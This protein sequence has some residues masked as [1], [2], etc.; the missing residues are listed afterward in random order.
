MKKSKIKNLSNMKKEIKI[1]KILKIKI[2]KQ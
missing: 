1:T 2:K